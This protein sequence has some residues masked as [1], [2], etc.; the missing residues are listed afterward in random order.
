V[1]SAARPKI[2]DYPFTTLAPQ[3]GV[4]GLS[5]SRSFV[6]ADVPGLIEG[7]HQGKGLGDRFLQ[8]IERTRV[9]AYLIPVDAADPQAVYDR[10][11]REVV[12]YSKALGEKPHLVVLTKL[13][14]RGPD[15][16]P[17]TIQAPGAR[18]VLTI[19][20]AAGTGLDRLKEAIWK[21]LH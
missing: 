21:L 12:L 2:A 17:P 11:R 10:L 8:H 1:V 18:S 19:S 20:A 7:A 14:L 9:L 5:G 15:L 16:P 6:M 13:D 4:V 3:L